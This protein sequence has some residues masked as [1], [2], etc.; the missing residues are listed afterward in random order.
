[1][2]VR[3]GDVQVLSHT[4]DVLGE[5][6]LWN[7]RHAAL[8]WI[9]LLKPALHRY[10]NGCT[11]SWTPPEKLGSYALCSDGGILMAG[12]GGIAHWQPETNCFE[13]V[14]T[15]EADRPDNI[16]N[17]GRCDPRGRF[18]VASM[19]KMLSAPRG[20]LWRVDHDRRTVLLQD[21]DIWLPNAIC[22]SPDGR[23]LYF[24]DSHTKTIFAYDYDLDTGT[25]TNR[26]LFADTSGLPGVPDGASVDAEGYVWNARFD[27]GR[28][29]RFAPN[30]T[31]DQV[32]ELPVS[33]PTHV[34]FGGPDLRTLY[35]TTARFRLH[36]DELQ[37]QPIAGALL[38]VDVDVAGLP[39]PCFGSQTP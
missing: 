3:V 25:P 2:P 6:P 8:T 36:R 29:L 24:G 11:T 13:R 26:R 22:F 32:V 19:D 5:V 28:L 7:M 4:Q 33:R 38:C 15:P 10:A 39:E 14:A 12:R 9:D 27:A 21:E 35:I 20:R 37:A 16:L 18:L 17:D 34:T 30:G 23:T 1:M 31:V